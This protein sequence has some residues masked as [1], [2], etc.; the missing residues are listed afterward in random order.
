MET[1]LEY[2]LALVTTLAIIAAP[3]VFGFAFDAIAPGSGLGGI[4][5]I[6]GFC[7]IPFI[8]V[9]AEKAGI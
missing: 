4:G 7:S 1:V 8:L 5:I 9:I 3:F 2:T 6:L